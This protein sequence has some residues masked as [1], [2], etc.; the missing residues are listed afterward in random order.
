MTGL[1][2]SLQRSSAQS[3]GALSARVFCSPRTLAALR[4]FSLLPACRKIHRAA[5]FSLSELLI[6]LAL[7]ALLAAGL[8]Q[9]AGVALR[10]SWLLREDAFLQGNARFARALLVR[11][12]AQAGY[13]PCRGLDAPF[14][15]MVAATPG[16]AWLFGAAP[17]IGY[18]QGEQ[19]WP[20][21]FAEDALPGT[22]AVLL[23]R[24]LA[25][26]EALLAG[27][28]TPQ[29]LLAG[30][31]SL[32]EGEILLL[33]DAGCRASVLFQLTGTGHQRLDYEAS[34]TVRPGNCDD[35]S[36]PLPWGTFAPGSAILPYRAVAYYI[37]SSAATGMP[38]LFRERLVRRQGGW[39]PAPRRCCKGWR[40]CS[41][42]T[43]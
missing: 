25:E 9:A 35:C 29:L 39:P 7:S 41:S 30:A 43:P 3:G 27:H 2:P 37:G 6:A 11:E 10:T 26:R 13:G 34:A 5:G 4:A 40:A 24:G 23:R 22:D 38:A 14:E 31:A 20:A 12:L 36:P 17:L 21:S 16:Y 42:A 1:C 18:E 19:D 15:N 33:A 8:L 28:S 32:E